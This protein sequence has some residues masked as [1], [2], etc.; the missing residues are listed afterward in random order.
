MKDKP[1]LQANRNGF[2][3]AVTT[4]AAIAAFLSGGIYIIKG[5]TTYLKPAE[6]PP[7][8]DLSSPYHKYLADV[9]SV[10]QG[11][12]RYGG[13]T[14]FAPLRSK[15]FI[16]ALKQ[17]HPLFNIQYHEHPGKPPGS[18]TEIEMLL[19]STKFFSVFSSC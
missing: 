3:R 16:L 13:S 18:G 4:I 7:P 12:F 5:I 6:L 1:E 9:P 10:P 2:L 17:S 14:T 19:G 11:T 15:D 8:I